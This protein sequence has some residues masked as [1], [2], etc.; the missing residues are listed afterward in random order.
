MLAGLLVTVSALGDRCGRKKTLRTGFALFGLASVAVLWASSPGEVIAVRALLG[1][2]GAMIMPSTLSMIRTLFAD[3]AER[4]S[5]LGIWAAMAALGSALG[6]ILGGL[7]LEHFSWHS[8]FLVNVPVMVLA[9]LAGLFLLPESRNPRPGRWD[10]AAIALSIAGMVALVISIKQFGKEGPATPW[11]WVALA[12][13]VVTLTWF[14]R[15]C[16]S[17]PDPLLE[18]RLFRSRPFSAGTL[19][20]LSTSIAMGA[21]MLLMAQWMQLVQ[22]YSPLETGVRLLPAA[23]GALLLSPLAPWLAARIGTCPVLGSVAAAVYRAALPSSISAVEAAR[24][25]PG[26]AIE[27]ARHVGAAGMELAHQAKAAFTASLQVTGLAGGLLML[28]VALAIWWLVPRDLDVTAGH[29]SIDGD[30]MTHNPRS[31]SSATSPAQ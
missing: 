23:L 15:P 2:G 10:M 29:A 25:F 11:P 16:L 24:D 19:A 21:V 5:A 28:A 8:V 27:A 26:G 13:A 30:G 3:P 6:P 17:Q 18:V 31:R 22:G 4:A 1:V 7:L 20:A 9:V 12:A 14:V